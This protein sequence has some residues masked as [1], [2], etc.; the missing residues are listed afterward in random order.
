MTFIHE[1]ACSQILAQDMLDSIGIND[2]RIMDRGTELQLKLIKLNIWNITGLVQYHLHRDH[3]SS[4]LFLAITTWMWT[5]P[6]S[7]A[8]SNN[9]S[10]SYLVHKYFPS[11]ELK[12]ATSYKLW[13]S[14]LSCW[15]DL[16][17]CCHRVGFSRSVALAQ[18]EG[19]EEVWCYIIQN[20]SQL[21]CWQC[22][23]HGHCGR[24]FWWNWS[25][26]VIHSTI[27]MHILCHEFFLVWMFLTITA[28]ADK[29]S[30]Q[31]NKASKCCNI[32]FD[33]IMAKTSLEKQV[34]RWDHLHTLLS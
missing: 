23:G 6:H 7:L 31:K 17:T 34:E 32:S 29:F 9:V 21:D 33:L 22:P 19:E 16:E 20:P 3:R 5:M 10:I 2:Y 27:C 28:G 8:F 18:D 30:D 1:V 26:S 14:P 4:H 12:I 11:L 24:P 13:P 15:W 25:M